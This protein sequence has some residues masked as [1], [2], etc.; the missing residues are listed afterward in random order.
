MPHMSWDAKNQNL[1]IT[2]PQLGNRNGCCVGKPPGASALNF[3]AS[4]RSIRRFCR[5]AKFSISDIHMSLKTVRNLWTFQ[6]RFKNFCCRPKIK[7]LS[8]AGQISGIVTDGPLGSHL[9]HLPPV[10]GP[11][12]DQSAH[13]LGG[14]N[15]QS[16]ALMW[17]ICEGCWW[18]TE[19]YKCICG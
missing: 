12:W 2:R 8:K 17:G 11:P 4:T 6:S 16:Q 13:S 7:I 1:E 19:S 10:S 3:S 15:L 9:A 14:Q 18:D 5:G